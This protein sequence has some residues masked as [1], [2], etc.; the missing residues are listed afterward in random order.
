MAFCGGNGA[1]CGAAF[2][3]DAGVVLGRLP[4]S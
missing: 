1:N 2:S 3:T 4:H